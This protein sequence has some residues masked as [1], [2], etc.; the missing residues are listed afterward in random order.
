MPKDDERARIHRCQFVV[1]L[2]R[3]LREIEDLAN[4]E[5]ADETENT[6]VAIR[7]KL[8]ELKKEFKCRA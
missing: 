6:V 7:S 4:H 8:K 3:A 5:D 2:D 1:H